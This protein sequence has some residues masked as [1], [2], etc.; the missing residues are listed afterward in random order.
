MDH[1]LRMHDPA[2]GRWLNRDPAGYAGGINLY[3]Y[4]GSNPRNNVDPLGLGPP[5][6]R[7]TPPGCGPGGNG[8]AT[9]GNAPLAAS[10]RTSTTP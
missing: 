4:V 8:G 3:E 9:P 7:V 5:L 1:R 2:I 10:R 6:G